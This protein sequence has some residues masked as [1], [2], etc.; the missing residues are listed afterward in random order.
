MTTKGV[1]TPRRAWVCGV[2]HK[3]K[4]KKERDRW[5]VQHG[6]GWLCICNLGHCRKRQ[7]GSFLSSIRAFSTTHDGLLDVYV[8]LAP[9]RVK[10]KMGLLRARARA[11]LGEGRERAKAKESKGLGSPAGNLQAF[12]CRL[13]LRL[14][15]SVMACIKMNKDVVSQQEV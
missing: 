10:M 2:L 6:V 4:K 8:T 11:P 13:L 5:G 15:F 3:K 1:S 9:C 7:E 14:F 12:C